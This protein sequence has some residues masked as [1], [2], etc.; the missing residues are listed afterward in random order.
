MKAL[1]VKDD[2][3]VDEQ[4]A[5]FGTADGFITLEQWNSSM[6]PELR[7]AIEKQLG[8]DDKVKG[9]RP[10]VD[11]AKVFD[12]FDTDKSGDLSLKEMKR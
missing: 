12:Q 11:V 5:K 2:L 3:G 6:T 1:G 4:F 8:D 7:A 9:F 10:L